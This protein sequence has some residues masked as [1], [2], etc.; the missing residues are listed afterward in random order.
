MLGAEHPKVYY[1][2]QGK[3]K[4]ILD[5]LPQLKQKYRP[6]LGSQIVM[7]TYF[8]LILLENRP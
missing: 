8:I 2:P 7:F 6:T 5:K 1:H 4:D 3:I